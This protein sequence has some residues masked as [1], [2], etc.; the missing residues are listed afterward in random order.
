MDILPVLTLVPFL[1]IFLRTKES[2]ECERDDS[3]VCEGRGLPSQDVVEAR[4]QLYVV[5]VDV[6]V[7][8]LRAQDFSDPHQLHR[9]RKRRRR[10]CRRARDSLNRST[11]SLDHR[12]QQCVVGAAEREDIIHYVHLLH[13]QDFI[14]YLII[15]LKAFSSC[16][17]KTS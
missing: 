1:L 14:L 12:S 16:F 2:T 9:R 3:G 17:F 15:K 11:F 6:V 7:Q 5:L 10:G 4:V 13:N 8:V